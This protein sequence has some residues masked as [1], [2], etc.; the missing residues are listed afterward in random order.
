MES[1][2]RT[3]L[4]TGA[5]S[6]IGLAT[7]ELLAARGFRVL[8]GVRSAAGRE[9][10]AAF[11][12]ANIETVS[13]D[14]TCADQVEC[15]MERIGELSPE[16]LYALV[17]NAGIGP[18]AAVELTDLD[19]LRQ[20]LEVN[21]LAP[22]RMMQACLPLLRRGRGRIVCMSSMNGTIALPMVGA[23]SASKFALEALCDSLRVE[24]RPWKIPVTV[25]RPGQVST[26]I[27]AKARIALSERSQMIP[28]ELAEGYSRLYA[29]AAKF[30]ERGAGMGAKPQAVARVVLKA[31]NARRPRASYIVGLDAWGLQALQRILPTRWLDSLLASASGATMERDTTSEHSASLSDKLTTS[32]A[33]GDR[34]QIPAACAAECSDPLLRPMTEILAKEPGINAG[35]NMSGQ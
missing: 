6:G 5:S 26:S 30:N 34:G 8:A 31:L 32:E 10:L 13:L 15:L 14:V 17:N 18:P 12:S 21:T 22:L 28:A 11:G 2:R 1:S 20:I 27:F 9:A 7:A 35:P 25:I 3:V 24:L 23:Y 29:R 16:G 19:E 33:E 4:V